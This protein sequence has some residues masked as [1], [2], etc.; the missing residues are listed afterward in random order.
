[1]TSAGPQDEADVPLDGGRS[2][3]VALETPVGTPPEGGWPGVVV[4]HEI[5]GLTPEVRDVGKEFAA[6]GWVAAVP[7]YFS[8]GTKLG[9]LVRAVAEVMSHKPGRVSDDLAAVAGWLGERSD[10]DARRLGAIGFCLGGGFALLLG[11][12]ERTGIKAVSVNYGDLPKDSY[13]E[14]LPPTVASYGGRDRSMKGRAAKLEARLTA[15][16]TVNDVKTY[17]NA[18]HSFLTPAR[19]PV[20]QV[21]TGPILHA[22][23]VADAAED[24]WPRIMGFL[25]EHV[26][27]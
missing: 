11:A 20:A 13:L 1:M 9:C 14:K 25:D 8:A 18:G 4:L 22:G 27:G 7:D 26:R 3:R 21:L 24:A 23:Y 19:H 16:G 15:C 5:F 10:V 6:R 12:V 2:M 17:D